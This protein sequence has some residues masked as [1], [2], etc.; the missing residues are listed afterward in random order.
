MAAR[1]ETNARPTI[2][3]IAQ[4]LQVTAATVS[5][6]LSGHP[7]ISAATRQAVLRTAKK[8]N[9]H[10]NGHAS[11][12]RSGRSRI[13]GVII[14]SA[15][16]HFFGS[17][18]HGIE[19]LASEHNYTVLLYQ[20]NEQVDFEKKGIATFLRSNVDGVIASVAK[21]ATNLSHYKTLR[22]HGV[23]LVL[24]DRAWDIGAATVTINDYKGAFMATRHL[25]EQ[26]CS[27]I[28]HIAGPLYIPIFQ[29]RLEGYKEALRQAGLKVDER[30]IVQGQVSIES[31]YAAAKK[32]MSLKSAPDGI[33]AVEDFTALGAL[34]QLKDS[35]I[36]V[37]QQVALAGF[38][39]EPFGEYITP[40]LTT[41]NQQTTLMGEEAARLFFRILE[42]KSGASGKPENLSLEPQLIVRQSSLRKTA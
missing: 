24:F 27:R 26:G 37:P 11:S 19:K 10:L 33:F 36:A 3:H 25:V 40:S 21:E 38:A 9:Y 28:A 30:L 39:D 2:R 42:K 12:L 18:V 23:P 20:S 31:G 16:I 14:P 6:A 5:R 22:R 41:I 13:I 17:V 29:Q 1:S 4:E 15:E 32:L 35:H 34:Q 7:A 8:L